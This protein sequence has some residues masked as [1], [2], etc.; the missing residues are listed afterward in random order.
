MK[1][2]A[3]QPILKKFTFEGP[4]KARENRRVEKLRNARLTA[5]ANNYGA[6]KG[7]RIQWR[8]FAIA[9]AAQHHPGVTVIDE[10]MPTYEGS[11]YQVLWM[12]LY[13]LLVAGRFKSI[14][15]ALRWLT[16]QKSCAW[17]DK[18]PETLKTRLYEYEANV[19]RAGKVLADFFRLRG[20]DAPL[21]REGPVASLKEVVATD[22]AAFGNDV[23]WAC[24][25]SEQ[26]LD[27]SGGKK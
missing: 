17:F 11:E 10:K 6:V 22:K 27:L 14:R 4:G 25:S 16:T 20:G 19:E 1:A 9:L 24:L 15:A 12:D 8:Q 7:G 3:E 13:H 18:D 5:L 21:L 2:P 26:I 23:P